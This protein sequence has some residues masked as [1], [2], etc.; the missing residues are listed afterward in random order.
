[1]SKKILDELPELVAAR[2]ISDET[3]NDIRNYYASATDSNPN[4]LLLIFSILGAVLSGL[5]I[6]LILAHNWDTLP[7]LAKA[8][9]S[10]LPLLI[11]Q[12]FCGYALLKKPEN[13]GWRE[14]ASAFLFFGIGA[15]IS[16]VAQVYN[17]PGDL[18]SFVL[19]W[20]V[21][22]LPQI[23]LM[24]SSIT[25]LLY[26]CGITFYGV[27]ADHSFDYY[28]YEY[29][30]LFAAI[31]PYYYQ[32]LRKH[33]QSNFVFFHNWFVCLSLIICITNTTDSIGKL[34]YLVYIGLFA[35]FY[36]IGMHPF[37]DRQKIRNNSYFIAG[38]VGTVI[39]LLALT[40]E[41]HWSWNIN[42]IPLNQIVI[43]QEFLIAVI[44]SVAALLL[45]VRKNYPDFSKIR[46]IDFAFLVI[47]IVFFTGNFIHVIAN[48]LVLL[49]GLSEMRRGNNQNNL[50]ILNYGLI[51][52]T[53]LVTCRF[54]D[55]EFSFIVRGMLFIAVGLGFF[56][57][58]YL[59]L[60]KRKTNEK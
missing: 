21:L 7:H 52:I 50:G 42:E 14:S 36:F 26:I 25:S 18:D 3:A 39:T 19:T 35:C 59:M 29:W 41:R 32:L 27:A 30:L 43:T 45:F 10:F 20:M 44:L 16:L 54:F 40:F 58:N 34:M 53:I 56:L 17:I 46:V 51:I 31:V 49:L 38:Q 28:N 5:G 6:I 33:P 23:Y 8:C 60:K 11:G 1:M 15:S 12:L 4:K 57:A 13:D 22:A 2:V 9:I 55:T 37:F 24:R 47:L 48:L